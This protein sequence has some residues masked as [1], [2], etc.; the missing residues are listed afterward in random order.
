MRAL[1]RFAGPER[2]ALQ[3]RMNSGL[4]GTARSM[5]MS[6]DAIREAFES[7]DMLTIYAP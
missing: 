5:G 1:V 6:E 7:D 3:S 2:V 4:I